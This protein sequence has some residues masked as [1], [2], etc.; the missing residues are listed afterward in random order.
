LLCPAGS[1]ITIV[2]YGGSVTAGH[3]LKSPDGSWVEQLTV[4]LRSA[5]PDVNIKTLNLARNSTDNVPA[6]ICWA[7]YAPADADLLV[8]EYSVNNCKYN[9]CTGITQKL[10][11]GCCKMQMQLFQHGQPAR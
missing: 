1:N 3:L 11:R 7:Q 5:F 4:W 9:T 2:T 6:A 10:V 8:V